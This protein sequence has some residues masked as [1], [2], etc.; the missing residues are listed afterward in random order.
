MKEF[1]NLLVTAVITISLYYSFRSIT[2]KS[3]SSKNKS[4]RINFNP[5]IYV[6]C[7]EKESIIN[8]NEYYMQELLDS[9]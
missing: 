4:K 5:Y 1:I 2:N 7:F 8:S 3:E 9:L 6:M